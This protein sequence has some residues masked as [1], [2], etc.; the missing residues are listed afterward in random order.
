MKTIF[1]FFK[2]FTILYVWLFYKNIWKVKA[3]LNQQFSPFLLSIYEEYMDRKFNSWIAYNSIVK[4]QPFFP[5]GP[6]GVF[7]SGGASIGKNSIIYQQVTIGSNTLY[8]H[9]NF[10]SPTIGDNVYI[11]SGAK[12]IGKITIGDNCRVG[13]NAV[14]YEDM[15]CN[16]I[17]VS[18]PTRIIKKKIP[19]DNRFFSE[20]GGKWYYY[21]NGHWIE[22]IKY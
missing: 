19:M 2:P 1:I 12:I 9:R 17:A 7:I 10:G 6:R 18:A 11:G 14:V 20:R 16:S 3:K 15:P 5:H 4:G 8:K 13:A 21:E 22:D